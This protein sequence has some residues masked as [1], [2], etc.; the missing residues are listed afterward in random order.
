MFK[1]FRF[2]A[3]TFTSSDIN[4][5]PTTLSKKWAFISGVIALLVSIPILAV[6]SSFFVSSGEIWSHLAETVLS[7]YISNSLLL[8]IGVSAGVVLTGVSLAWIIT[9][10][11]FPG[12][13]YF[14][15]AA[16]LPFSIPAYLLA[17]IYTDFLGT[18]GTL[19]TALRSTFELGVNDYFFPEIRSVW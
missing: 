10:C 5:Y 4:K 8:I 19:Q 14:E 15:W 13:K 12:Q 2:L 18:T 9:M 3:G 7:D 1:A 17:Y 11:S 16:V 6:L